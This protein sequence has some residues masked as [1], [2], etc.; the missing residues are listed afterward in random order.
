MTWGSG[1][2]QLWGLCLEM[3]HVAGY[4]DPSYVR[5]LWDV[6]LK[7]AIDAALERAGGGAGDPAD[8]ALEAA[9]SE[10][11]TLGQRLFPSDSRWVRSILAATSVSRVC[12]PCSQ[13]E[14]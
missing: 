10:V 13:L 7:A 3:V 14:L 9:A 5:Q 2:A 12:L 8:A 6:H 11:A 1:A 4:S